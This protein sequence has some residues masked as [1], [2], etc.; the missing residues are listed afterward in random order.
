MSFT[1]VPQYL[2][3][4]F[5]PLPFIELEALKNIRSLTITSVHQK[6]S[7]LCIRESL[8]L[9]YLEWQNISP[10]DQYS[11]CTS[12]SLSRRAS[13]LSI[14]SLMDFSQGS[15][16][17]VL[18][19]GPGAHDRRTERSGRLVND[20]IVTPSL[21]RSPSTLLSISMELLNECQLLHS[22]Y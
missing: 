14:A 7:G 18:R 4:A 12:C 22:F 19:S 13:G 3:P 20:F 5:C 8:Q 11:D 10:G 17:A 16:G 21:G 2:Q 1:A 9:W 6:P 15:R